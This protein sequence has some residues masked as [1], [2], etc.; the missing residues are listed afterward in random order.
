MRAR[1]YRDAHLETRIGRVHV[2]LEFGRSLRVAG[3]SLRHGR[4]LGLAAH[5]E[6]LDADSVQP[7]IDLMRLAHADDVGRTIAASAGL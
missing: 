2:G 4:A 5:C 7:N 6:A 3:E 1:L